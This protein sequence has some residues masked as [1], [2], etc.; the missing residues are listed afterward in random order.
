MDVIII[1]NGGHSKVVREMIA[2]MKKYRVIAILDDKF[3]QVN[4]RENVIYAP[5]S[6]LNKQLKQ[7]VKIVIAIGNN[8]VRELLFT[9]LNLKQS[10][11][12]TVIHPS[13]V[14]SKTATIGYGT[15]VM[16]NALINAEASIGNHCII[17]T[18]AI[19]EH[20]N[21][22]D[23]YSHISPNATLTGNVTVGKGVHIG[24]AATIIPGITIG[25]WSIIGAGSTVIRNIPA[26]RTAVGNPTRLL[27]EKKGKSK[28]KVVI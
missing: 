19:I 17:N 26:N 9:K 5:L 16:P 20:E 23:H 8:K 27:D 15:V 25:S 12:L 24:A 22:I 14:V 28:N 10:Q 7:D 11:Y 18:G 4:K 1:G 3:K 21:K 6:F 13:A 2:C